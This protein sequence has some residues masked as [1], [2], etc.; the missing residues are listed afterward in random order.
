M[1][2][3][4]I[5]LNMLENALKNMLFVAVKCV[6]VALAPNSDHPCDTITSVELHFGITSGGFLFMILAI[7]NIVQGTFNLTF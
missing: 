2:H 3:V 7:E 5:F 4:I 6:E 1:Y